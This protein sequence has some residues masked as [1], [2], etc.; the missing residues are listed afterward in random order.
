[1][2][3]PEKDILGGNIL[4]VIFAL[5][6]PVIVSSL[7]QIGYNMADT[8]WLGRW[9]SANNAM[10]AVAAM[11]IAWPLI[12]VMIS[13]TTGFAIAGISIVSQYTGAK[14]VN[15]AAEACGQLLS[16]G[17]ILG[18]IIGIVGIL[19]APILLYIMNP[20]PE[21]A[22][23]AYQYMVIIFLGLPFMF[24]TSIFIS[25]LRAY[26]DSIT[27]MKVSAIGVGLN[28]ILDPILIN[29]FLGFPEM[30][31][32]GAATA[33]VITRGVATII[34]L[35]ILFKGVGKLRV[36]W[37]YL[38]LKIKFAKKIFHI[39]LPAS[40]GQFSSSI[41][42]FILMWIIASL[43]NSTV[44]LAAYGVGDR[45]IDVAF[46]IISGIGIG[47][48]TI[49]G[50]SLG[51]KK[52]ERARAA[53][54]EALKLTFLILTIETVIIILFRYQ[55]VAFFIPKSQAVIDEGALFLLIFSLGIPFFGIIASVEGVYEG[56]GNT[57]PLMIIDIVRL[58]GFRVLFSYILG[59]LLG[60]GSLGVWV[61][62]AISNI[63][64]AGV[65]LGFY[66]TGSW[67]MRVIE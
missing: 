30:G 33:T 59:I 18:I 28:I 16:L 67:K 43:P 4:K 6:W 9:S 51:A 11:Q 40:M 36:K 7:L 31:V 46:I 25:V 17:I 54:K 53:F 63:A 19:I 8:F 35:Y 62:M 55:L 34:S 14:K 24:V 32:I 5:G 47:M 27:P 60:F 58:W 41:G 45:I 15:K 64:S 66:F 1:M 65:A 39:G 10:N 61:G 13:L 52:Y 20:D 38:K 57:K 48:A 22:K 26:G 44:A 49:I 3:V 29:G 42:I 2:K 50:H 21:V 23:Y 12:F 37:K 56:A